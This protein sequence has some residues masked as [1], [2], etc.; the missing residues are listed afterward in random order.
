M[1]TYQN[2]LFNISFR[3]GFAV[4]AVVWAAIVAVL[5]VCGWLCTCFPGFLSVYKLLFW[6]LCFSSSHTF[7][8]FLQKMSHSGPWRIFS[9]KNHA[10]NI[11]GQESVFP[12]PTTLRNQRSKYFS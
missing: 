1:E 9:S 2:I 11:Y 5:R 3:A 12:K 6:L 4:F 10:C 8:Y 7:F